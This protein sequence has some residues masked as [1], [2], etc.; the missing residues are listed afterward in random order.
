MLHQD[1]TMLEPRVILMNIKYSNIYVDSILLYH[2]LT[3]IFV[4]EVFYTDMVY[5]W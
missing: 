4:V 2:S 1:N 5:K 3:M